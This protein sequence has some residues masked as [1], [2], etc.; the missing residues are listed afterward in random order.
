LQLYE[1]L[2]EESIYPANT[3]EKLGALTPTGQEGPNVAEVA[4]EEADACEDAHHEEVEAEE[5]CAA[6][7]LAGPLY[8]EVLPHRT[9]GIPYIFLHYFPLFPLS[10]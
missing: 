2:A 6:L 3:R 7:V 4:E 10:Y 9:L 8:V 1:S 5:D